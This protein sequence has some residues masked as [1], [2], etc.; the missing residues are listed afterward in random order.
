VA[1]KPKVDTSQNTETTT[2][3][4]YSVRDITPGML[5]SY[6]RQINHIPI[7]EGKYND[8]TQILSE[9]AR[10]ATTANRFDGMNGPFRA[11]VLKVYEPQSTAMIDSLMA[12]K[13]PRLC[14]IRAMLVEFDQPRPK[15][16][17]EMIETEK[18]RQGTS[19]DTGFSSIDFYPLYVAQHADVPTPQVGDVVWV[20]YENVGQQLGGIYLAPVDGMNTFEFEACSKQNTCTPAQLKAKQ[21]KGL[22]DETKDSVHEQVLFQNNSAYRQRGNLVYYPGVRTSMV[23]GIQ[24]VIRTQ[25]STAPVGIS[26]N[27]GDDTTTAATEYQKKFGFSVDG[28]IGALEL[29]KM[30]EQGMPIWFRIYEFLGDNETGGVRMNLGKRPISVWRGG[31]RGSSTNWVPTDGAG[32]NYGVAGLNVTE[33]VTVNIM[34]LGVKKKD[35]TILP[36][37]SIDILSEI[38]KHDDAWWGARP[39]VSSSLMQLLTTYGGK[40]GSDLWKKYKPELLKQKAIAEIIMRALEEGNATRVA[41]LRPAIKFIPEIADWLESPAGVRAQIKYM[42][43]TYI[44]EILYTY[45]MQEAYLREKNQNVQ[46]SPLALLTTMFDVKAQYGSPRAAVYSYWSMTQ[47]VSDKVKSGSDWATAYADVSAVRNKFRN[48]ALAR[49]MTIVK[50]EGV[51]H[52]ATVKMSD[53]GLTA[54]WDTYAASEIS[55]YMTMGKSYFLYEDLETLLRVQRSGQLSKDQRNFLTKQIAQRFSELK[56]NDGF[57]ASQKTFMGSNN[58]AE[59]IQVQLNS[60][61]GRATLQGIRDA[62]NRIWFKDLN[63][64]IDGIL[65]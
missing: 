15:V 33:R 13:T 22:V 65:Q 3:S 57:Y 31:N 28:M 48:D 46:H 25:V 12:S 16:T 43:N 14:S 29:S 7:T 32:A 24:H 21:L 56:T 38:R 9:M 19:N 18:Q 5:N 61:P 36:P 49:H 35:I 51:I 2:V 34:G 62:A 30:F 20:T 55:S 37:S 41:E 17:K 40:E 54:N 63:K 8:F 44:G 59:K 23:A 42:W 6:S 10:R 27:F 39:K 60:A 1:D 11:I 45:Q 26:G 58:T 52:G 50:G 53:Y 4:A 64:K 47:A